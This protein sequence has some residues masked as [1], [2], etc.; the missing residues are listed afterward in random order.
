MKIL[1][2]ALRERLD[3]AGL[4]VREA[5]EI[6]GVSHATVA[7]AANGETVEVD[8]LI[9]IAEFLKTP[10]E[11]LLIEEEKHPDHLKTLLVLMSTEPELVDVLSKIT[12]MVKDEIIDAKILSEI[13]A[14]ATFR[15][16]EHQKREKAK[17]P[18]ST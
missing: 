6:I 5:A 3:F 1:A 9:K 17:K 2:K 8:T 12:K 10:V 13:S 11:S 16:D 7:R 4:S 18:P 14:F 15:L